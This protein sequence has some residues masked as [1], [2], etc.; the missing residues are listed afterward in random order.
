[1]DSPKRRIDDGL[2]EFVQ[3]AEKIATMERQLITIHEKRI[4][5]FEQISQAAQRG[6]LKEAVG[7]LSPWTALWDEV[8]TIQG[9]IKMIAQQGLKSQAPEN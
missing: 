8:G 7:L 6:D 4:E 1:M 3:V 5:C 2:K 9:Q